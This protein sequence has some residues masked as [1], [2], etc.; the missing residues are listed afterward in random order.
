MTGH[1]VDHEIGHWWLW[2]AKIARKYVQI[3][4]TI[5]YLRF[6]NEMLCILGNILKLI[7]QNVLIGI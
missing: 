5:C 3:M 6:K 2:S 7:L 4:A 1:D